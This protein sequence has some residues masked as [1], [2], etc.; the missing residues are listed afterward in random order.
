MLSS[1][2]YSSV[3]LCCALWAYCATCTDNMGESGQS[4]HVHARSHVFHLL[5]TLETDLI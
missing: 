5:I 1:V 4:A 3:G 2:N